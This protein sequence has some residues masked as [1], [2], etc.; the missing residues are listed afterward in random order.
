LHVLNT[1]YVGRTGNNRASSD[2]GAAVWNGQAGE[3]LHGDNQST[4]GD[5]HL[6]HEK[7]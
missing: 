3:L 7:K 5:I 4:T 1:S 2:A 6:F